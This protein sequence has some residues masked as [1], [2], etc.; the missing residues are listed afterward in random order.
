L[1][2]PNCHTSGPKL[3]LQKNICPTLELE[4]GWVIPVPKGYMKAVKFLCSPDF[5]RSGQSESQCNEKGAWT[6]ESP[7]CISKEQKGIQLHTYL[8]L[9]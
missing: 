4:N 3:K 2:T 6:G 7:S 8:K 9:S 1:H 5:E